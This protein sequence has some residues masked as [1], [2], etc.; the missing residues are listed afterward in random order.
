MVALLFGILLFGITLSQGSNWPG[1]KYAGNDAMQ[2]SQLIVYDPI[3]S[4][5]YKTWMNDSESQRSNISRKF[6]AYS[7][8]GSQKILTTKY[9]SHSTSY[10]S[11]TKYLNALIIAGNMLVYV[12]C[13]VGVYV[14][15]KKC[16]G[17]FT[18]YFSDIDFKYQQIH[19]DP[20]PYSCKFVSS[21]DDLSDSDDV[22]TSDTDES[23]GTDS[24]NDGLS[25]YSHLET[26]SQQ[27]IYIVQHKGM[28]L[29]MSL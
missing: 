23:T 13:I 4:N 19:D 17:M 3:E 8:S 7:Y 27:E 20:S 11:K 14:S 16:C 26:D 9:L 12:F 2:Q 18:S 22:T 15:F 24:L 5:G 10:N 25:Y 21:D 28:E 1:S 6:H 29:E